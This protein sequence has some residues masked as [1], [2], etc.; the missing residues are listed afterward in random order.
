MA[1]IICFLVPHFLSLFFL[2]SYLTPLAN[3]AIPNITTTDQ[4]ALMALK[5][6]ISDDP[7]DVLTHNWSTNTTAVCN[8]I[9]VTC[10]YR[11]LRVTALN[12]SYMDLAGTIPPHIGNLSFL[13]SLM[14]R[15][16]SFHG[17]IPNELSLLHRLRFL[18]FKYNEFNGEMLTKLQYLSFW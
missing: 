8:W 10:G 12:L 5:A 3:A 15:N 2:E 18:H 1:D 14:I 16:N 13:V 17:S 9:G 11:H 7:H 4:S 6:S